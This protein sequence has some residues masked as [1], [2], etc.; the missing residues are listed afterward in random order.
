MYVAGVDVGS[1]TSKAV[2]LDSGG[3]IAAFSKVPTTHDRTLSGRLAFLKALQDAGVPEAEVRYVVATG[4]G[5]KAVAFS[6]E[7]RPEILCHAEGT[8]QIFADVR[9]IIDIGGQDSK[10]I[11]LDGKGMVRKFQMNDKCAAGTG[12][13]L[14]VLA[15]RILG[16][17]LEELGRAA[18]SS[19][20]PCSLTSVC[21]V[22]A[23]SEIVALLSEGKKREDIAC[24]LSRAIARRVVAMG[25]G[26]GLAFQTPVCFSG[27]VALNVGVVEALKQELKKPVLVPDEPQIPAAL[28]AAV[29]ARKKTGTNRTA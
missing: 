16:L 12:R 13:F 5:R 7:S 17:G 25:L 24:G 6:D 20:N 11:D 21:T 9:T 15:E 4:Y 23:E 2:L 26:E 3:R 27:G 19:R 14:E 22:F 29:W 1:V 28:G 8:R 10:V 18:L